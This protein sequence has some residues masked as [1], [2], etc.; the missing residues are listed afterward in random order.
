MAQLRVI[1]MTVKMTTRTIS[2]RRSNLM[3]AVMDSK[4]VTERTSTSFL[5]TPLES[6]SS[7]SY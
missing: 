1:A 6:Q 5:A 3:T 2:M 7:S 4:R